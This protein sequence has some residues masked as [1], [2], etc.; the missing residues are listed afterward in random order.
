MKKILI[1]SDIFREITWNLPYVG[2]GGHVHNAGFAWHDA[3]VKGL[4]QVN[5]L[6]D[7]FGHFGANFNHVVQCWYEIRR[8]VGNSIGSAGPHYGVKGCKRWMVLKK[9]FFGDWFLPHLN[10]PAKMTCHF[11]LKLKFQP[12]K[13]G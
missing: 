3:D 2:V 5:G 11:L 13:C 10:F 4:L 7:H 12:V 9:G 1:Q 6:D 8:I